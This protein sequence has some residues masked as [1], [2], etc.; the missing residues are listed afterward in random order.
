MIGGIITR[1]EEMDHAWI[2]T[3]IDKNADEYQKNLEECCARYMTPSCR[4]T[5]G[6]GFVPTAFLLVLDR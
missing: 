5:N 4:H 3:G 2:T 6:T 1:K